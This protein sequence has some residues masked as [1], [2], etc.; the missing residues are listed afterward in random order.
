MV[1][2][3]GSFFGNLFSP[4][5]MWNFLWKTFGNLKFILRYRSWWTN[6]NT[7]ILIYLD[8]LSIYI[9]SFSISNFGIKSFVDKCPI[10]N[11]NNITKTHAYTHKWFS[12]AFS[13]S[14]CVNEA[15]DSH[16]NILTRK[17]KTNISRSINQILF[18]WHFLSY[19]VLSVIADEWVLT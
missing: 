14:L 19:K 7:N 18:V 9:C 4:S 12:S 5:C 6:M 13:L 11:A 8:I 2:S 1:F 3:I 15:T 16:D 17:I 10:W